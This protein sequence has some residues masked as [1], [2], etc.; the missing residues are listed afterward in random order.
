MPRRCAVLF[1][2]AKNKYMAS[3]AAR[4][5][6]IQGYVMH[7]P[8]FAFIKKYSKGECDKRTV[9]AGLNKF[10]RIYTEAQRR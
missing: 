5:E 9:A 6:V 4:N 1:F 3:I 8:A 10:F 7:L 2:A